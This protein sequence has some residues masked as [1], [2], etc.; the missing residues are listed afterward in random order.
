MAFQ[1]ALKDAMQKTCRPANFQPGNI[2]QIYLRE[3]REVLENTGKVKKLRSNQVRFS[4]IF[5]ADLFIDLD[6][7]HQLTP[8]TTPLNNQAL[9]RISV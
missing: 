6:K 2:E 5:A 9:C 1:I 3:S 4:I 7:I 8:A